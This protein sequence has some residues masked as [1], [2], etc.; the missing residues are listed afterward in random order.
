MNS[1]VGPTKF[2]HE[3]TG[4]PPHS[5]SVSVRQQAREKLRGDNLVVG[6]L[7]EQRTSLE[8]AS[9]AI[10]AHPAF[11]KNAVGGV[12]GGVEAHVGHP[13]FDRRFGEIVL[14]VVDVAPA[15]LA[16]IGLDP[17]L[18]GKGEPHTFEGEII[19]VGNAELD[20]LRFD[21]VARLRNGTMTPPVGKCGFRGFCS[22]RGHDGK[23]SAFGVDDLI[24]IEKFSRRGVE[25]ESEHLMVAVHEQ[26]TGD[27]WLAQA[28]AWS[29][30][31]GVVLAACLDALF[32]YE[33]NA[34]NLF[35]G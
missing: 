24:G 4:A 10:A 23:G 22:P 30:A 35:G 31:T 19:G 27:V 3:L 6:F 2:G 12:V 9:L 32:V 28:R 26:V 13:F 34:R 5:I 1:S 8:Q 29:A 7:I 20:Q 14:E 16:S 11:G 25:T 21:A 17:V 33:P 15:N 18:V